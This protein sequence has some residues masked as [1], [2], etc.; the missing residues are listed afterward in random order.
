MR[1]FCL[2]GFLFLFATSLSAMVQAGVSVPADDGYYNG[3][4]YDGAY[5]YYGYNSYWYG[6]GWYWGV[7]FNNQNDYWGYRRGGW[8]HGPN[9]WHGRGYH[10]GGGGHHGGGGRHHGGGGGGHHHH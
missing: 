2:F 5:P 7:Y 8:Y 3:Y 1:K 4:Y 6:P 10:N 9:H